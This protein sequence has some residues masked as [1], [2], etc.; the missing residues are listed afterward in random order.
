[1]RHGS[2]PTLDFDE[3]ELLSDVIEELSP[4][5]VVD[6][7]LFKLSSRAGLRVSEVAHLTLDAFFDPRGRMRDEIYVTVT[8]WNTSREI[9]MHPE[10]EDALDRFMSTYPG[11][12]YFAVSPRDGRQMRPPALAMHMK[13][14]FEDFGFVGCTS[15][16]GRATFITE[17]ARRH[18]EFECSLWDVMKIAGH[19]HL[20]STAR[21]LRPSDRGREL[22]RALGRGPDHQSHTNH[23]GRENHGFK[24]SRRNNRHTHPA[25]ILRH[26]Q[27]EAWLAEQFARSRVQ[28]QWRSE[29]DRGFARRY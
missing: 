7:M 23:R 20:S 24:A 15:H 19:K 26:R 12:R 25:Q 5:P 16:S 6:D 1:M 3:L 9:F 11:L 22:V 18:N 14:R 2:A 21:Y 28:P 29:R 13:R 17:L 4:D 27:H 8:K 10:I